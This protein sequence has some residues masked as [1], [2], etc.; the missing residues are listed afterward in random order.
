M[1]T[2]PG[3]GDIS[4]PAADKLEGLTVVVPAY[5]EEGSLERVV[6]ETLKVCEEIAAEFEVIVI[7]DGS[8]DR[9][10]K[11]ADGMA[12]ENERVRVY[13]HPF[14]LGFGASQK[15]GFGYARYP[16]V[17]LIPADGQFPIE[18]LKRYVPLIEHVDCVVGY[19][20]KRADRFLRRV[21]TRVFRFVMWLLFGVKLHDCNWVKLFRKSLLDGIEIESYGIGVDAEVIAKAMRRGHK[22]AEIEVRYVPRTSGVSTG[23]RPLRVLVTV[24]ELL[25]LRWRLW[26]GKG[27]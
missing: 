1:E 20:V 14:N 19:R 25:V 17:T 26:F 27:R 12:E 8:R 2:A 24:I 11:I 13:H 6:R 15:S 16:F 23:D 18:D 21:S 4:P 22:F 9:T 3:S 5:N 10:R 7:N